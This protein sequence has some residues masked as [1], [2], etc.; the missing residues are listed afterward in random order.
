M[1]INRI[2]ADLQ[3]KDGSEVISNFATIGDSSTALVGATL[4]SSG[5]VTG[6]TGTFTDTLAGGGAHI[7]VGDHKY[8]V[9]GELSVEASIEAAMTAVDASCKGSLYSGQD[10]L[11]FFKSD[12]G[13]SA[14]TG[15]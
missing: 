8:I 4:T 15:K 3:G 14:L 13:A 7:Q 10:S 6:T 11:W 5:A 1:S 12:T 2:T 9:F